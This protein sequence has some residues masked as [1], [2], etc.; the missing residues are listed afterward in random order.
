MTLHDLEVT[1]ERLEHVRG[2]VETLRDEVVSAR[3]AAT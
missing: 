2:I 3:P 1:P